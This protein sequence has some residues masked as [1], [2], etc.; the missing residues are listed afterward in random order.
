[1]GAANIHKPCT[2]GAS[3]WWQPDRH[4]VRVERH[5]PQRSGRHE[6]PDKQRS[7]EKLDAIVAA[8]MALLYY[9]RKSMLLPGCNR[10]KRC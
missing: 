9:K 1:M 6:K 4:L 5:G 8:V 2:A 3:A 7:T 10:G